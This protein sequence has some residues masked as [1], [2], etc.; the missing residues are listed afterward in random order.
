MDT[1][2]AGREASGTEATIAVDSSAVDVPEALSSVRDGDDEQS[3]SLSSPSSV[4]NDKQEAVEVSS[5]S[6][7]QLRADFDK[8]VEVDKVNCCL[9]CYVN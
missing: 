8:E 6:Q 7:N 9:I 3:S 2:D 5:L 1:C 4:G